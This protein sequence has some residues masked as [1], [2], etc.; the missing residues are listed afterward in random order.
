MVPLLCLGLRQYSRA[1]SSVQNAVRHR[2]AQAP[3][4]LKCGFGQ[5]RMNSKAALE[6]I[7]LFVPS[8]VSIA[9]PFC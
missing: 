4:G 9:F 6:F 7:C 2:V 3:R 5:K 8:I 1:A